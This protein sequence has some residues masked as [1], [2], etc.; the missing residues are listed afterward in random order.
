MLRCPGQD[1]GG[2]LEKPL[3]YAEGAWWC[4]KCGEDWMIMH[5]PQL[6]V[7]Y[8]PEKKRPL[9]KKKDG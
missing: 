9:Q 3:K 6:K 5:I 2:P 7:V 4:S 1:C 8:G